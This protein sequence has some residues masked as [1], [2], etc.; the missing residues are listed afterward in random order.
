MEGIFIMGT[1]KSPTPTGK[2]ASTGQAGSSR[3]V[4]KPATKS[5]VQSRNFYRVSLAAPVEWQL[6]NEIGQQ[7]DTHQ[8]ELTNIS[9]GG[10]AFKT[11]AAGPAPGDRMHILLTGLPL[12]GKLDT[13]VTVLRVTPAPAPAPADDEEE[14]QKPRWQR[15]LQQHARAPY[16]QHLRTTANLDSAKYVARHAAKATAFRQQK[17]KAVAFLCLL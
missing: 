14:E 5:Y 12:I 13:N 17:R 2:S 3:V 15:T 6:L 10:L 9:G 11:E 4:D 16:F 7:Q 1:L 8:G